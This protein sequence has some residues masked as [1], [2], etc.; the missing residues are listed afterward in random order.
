MPRYSND[1][2]TRTNLSSLR[3]AGFSVFMN[4]S[5][6]DSQHGDLIYLDIIGPLQAIRGV[7]ATLK[8]KKVNNWTLGGSTKMYKEP[9]H[10]ILKSTLPCGYHNW[11]IISNQ[12]IPRFIR[13]DFPSYVWYPV[14]DKPDFAIPPP[15]FMSVFETVCPFPVKSS[16]S[17][18]L[19]QAGKANKLIHRIHDTNDIR[20]FKIFMK[21]EQWQ[22]LVSQL[23]RAKTV[24]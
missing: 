8:S 12:A 13:H 21:Q 22:L 23:V 11:T 17:K 19:W 2:H 7:W 20:A 16:W 18:E 10:Y 6:R 24:N 5:I 1:N 9:G 14:G 15:S 4:G 3:I